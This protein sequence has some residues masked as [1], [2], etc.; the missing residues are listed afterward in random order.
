MPDER[1][2]SLA[3]EILRCAQDD[4]LARFQ[5]TYRSWLVKFII[6]SSSPVESRHQDA[7]NHVPTTGASFYITGLVPLNLTNSNHTP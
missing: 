1:A 7:I 2:R 4:T 5:A 3:N 6:A